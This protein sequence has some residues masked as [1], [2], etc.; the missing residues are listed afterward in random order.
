MV[1][2]FIYQ[3]TPHS[4]WHGCLLC[5]RCWLA[6]WQGPELLSKWLGESERALAAIFKRARAA[7]PAI[8]F[9]DEIDAIA[10]S[11]GSGDG[12]NTTGDRLL[13]QLLVEMDGVNSKAPKTSQG[14]ARAKLLQQERELMYQR[15]AAI[16]EEEAA[17]QRRRAAAKHKATIG[18]GSGS[19]SGGS[20]SGCSGSGAGGGEGMED[21]EDG[22]DDD[23]EAALSLRKTRKA[24][25]KAAEKTAEMKLRL[26]QRVVVVAATNRM[27]EQTTNS[28]IIKP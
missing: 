7:A 5:V 1:R 21:E 3:S 18:G 23:R 4:I 19:G 13:T 28:L 10:A 26:Q 24:E 9:F 16:Q 2:W 11:R 15:Q 22:E 12:S 25:L 6:C 27:F 8:I 17:A 20:G 14:A